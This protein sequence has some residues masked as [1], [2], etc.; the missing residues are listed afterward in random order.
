[1][2]DTAQTFISESRRYLSGEFLPKIER[3]LESLSDEEVWWRANPA[4]NSI[5]NL[6]LH[7]A[8]NVGQWI[9]GGVGGSA[10]ERVRQQEF[11]ERRI[12]PRAELLSRLARTIAEADRVLAEL[13]V[14]S[15]SERRLIQ[16]NDVTVLEAVYHVVEHFSMHMGQI[17]LLA[18]MRTG[19]D[20]SFYEVNDEGVALPRW[21]SERS[22]SSSR[23]D[24]SSVED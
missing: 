5:G 8:G 3:C 20:M 23:G 16:G 6:M 10:V 18:K 24:S 9:V 22:D 7:L 14:E 17:I 11:D 15:L 21:Q 13:T 19:K 1:M 12:L 4:S 2:N